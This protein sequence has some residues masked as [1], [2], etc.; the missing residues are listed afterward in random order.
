[1]RII[2]YMFGEKL[3]TRITK[4][5]FYIAWLS[6]LPN[7]FDSK[8]YGIAWMNISTPLVLISFFTVGLFSVFAN[9]DTLIDFWRPN[10]RLGKDLADPQ[11]GQIVI[12]SSRAVGLCFIAFTTYAA[13]T[14]F[15]LS[16]L[17]D[18]IGPVGGPQ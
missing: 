1:M 5:I 16:S 10:S 13:Y 12:Y 6:M 3:A 18:T 14:M 9:K 11:K 15:H 8:W 7:F 4:A 17:R 2:N